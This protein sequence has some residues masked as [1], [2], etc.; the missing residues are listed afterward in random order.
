MSDAGGCW[1]KVHVTSKGLGL[2]ATISACQNLYTKAGLNARLICGHCDEA[3]NAAVHPAGLQEHMRAI[4]V[5]H[6]E[7]QAV[8]EGIVHMRLHTSTCLT[9]IWSG[10]RPLLHPLDKRCKGPGVL[11]RLFSHGRHRT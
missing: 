1:S 8:A 6:G 10:L 9:Q 2:S 11:R 7:G 3:A 4:G 5:V